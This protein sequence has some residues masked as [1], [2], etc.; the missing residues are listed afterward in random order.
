MTASELFK[1][2]KLRE[3]LTAQTQEVKSRPADPDRR[4]FLF[5]LL[6]FS[7]DLDRAGKQMDAVSYGELERDGAVQTYRN[8]LNAEGARR[9]LLSDGVKPRFFADIPDHI[10][11]RLE[12]INRLREGNRAEAA[13]LLTRA[14]T[15]ART[16][17]GKLND[18]PF[19]LLRDCDDLF[20]HVLEV[21]AHGE[22]Y[23]VPLEQ[24]HALAVT[25]PRFPRDLLWAPAR[26]EMADATG[27][28]FLPLLYPKSHEHP[29][30][31]VRL[32]RMTD[33]SGGDGTPVLGA[34]L[35]TFL[36][37]EDAVPLMQWQHY[38]IAVDEA[39]AG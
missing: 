4:L 18:K 2:G 8:L 1:A 15:A 22:Y 27:D 36:V 21:M 33:W 16:I 24:V 23:W 6:A 19:T 35:R 28:V 9:R 5:E 13:E 17:P 25:S 7:G 30:D 3:A 20:G 12:A 37:D 32:G 31:A 10:P 14:N 29:D 26:L 34:G 38:E 11:L 39:P